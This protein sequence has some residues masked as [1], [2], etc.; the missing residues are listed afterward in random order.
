MSED[1][2]HTIK[3]NNDRG[4]MSLYPYHVQFDVDNVN[5][6]VDIATVTGCDVV[7]SHKGQLMSGI[8]VSD[9]VKVDS[10]NLR[11]DKITIKN[12]N[13]KRIVK[14]HIKHIREKMI[15]TPDLTEVLQKRVRSLTSSCIEIALPNDYNY[16][17]DS[18]ELDEAIRHVM[19]I[20]SNSPEMSEVTRHHLAT[21][22]S[23][24]SDIGIAV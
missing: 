23:L 21:L 11:Q 10:S 12:S 8:K 2:T 18:M 6:L 9:L 4:I 1:V 15:V 20:M 3:V 19:A 16:A 5:T 14:N 17:A 13:T 22:K 24:I 7:S